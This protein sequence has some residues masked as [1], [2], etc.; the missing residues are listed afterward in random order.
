MLELCGGVGV[1]GMSL[2]HA[3]GTKVTL[4]STDSNPESGELFKVNAGTI[5]SEEP[6]LVQA[7]FT[8]LAADA[9]LRCGVEALGG[10]AEVLIL[11]PPR[12]G[13]GCRSWRSGRPAGQEEVDQIRQSLLARPRWWMSA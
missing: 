10:P 11:D 13:L 3:A 1:I 2:A 7:K 4:L 12:R 5:F 6:R 9:A 8:A